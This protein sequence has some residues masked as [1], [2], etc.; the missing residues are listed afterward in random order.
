M[1]L[2]PYTNFHDLNLDWLLQQLRKAVFTVNNTEPDANGNVNLA[3]VSGVTSVN[4]IGADGSGNISLSAADVNAVPA[5]YIVPYHVIGTLDPDNTSGLGYAYCWTNTILRNFKFTLFTV[6]PTNYYTVMVNGSP[7]YRVP[8]ASF[9][10]NPFALPTTSIT[11]PN[12]VGGGLLG[13]FI[14]HQNQITESDTLSWVDTWICYDGSNT[15]MFFSLAGDIDLTV[16]N[17]KFITESTVLI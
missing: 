11:D 2:F 12:I 16:L 1:N 15:I 13:T 8:I 14:L 6:T 9:S 17:G 7:V 5:S 10:G 4:G 3:G